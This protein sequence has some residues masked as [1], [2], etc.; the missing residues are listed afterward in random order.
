MKEMCRKAA[1]SYN[2]RI[3]ILVFNY[4]TKHSLLDINVIDEFSFAGL[5]DLNY[6]T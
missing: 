6:Y 3:T 4:N 2:F 5:R 1:Q